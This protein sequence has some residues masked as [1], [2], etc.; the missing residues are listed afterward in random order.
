MSD[1]HVRSVRVVAAVWVRDGRVLAA[2]RGPGQSSAGLWELPGG[3]VEAGETDDAALVREIAEELAC[4]I[5]VVGDS[6]GTSEHTYP[7][8]RVHVVAYP[9]RGVA[10][11]GGSDA[12]PMMT[13]H[14]ALRWLAAH[15]LHEVDWVPADTA[16]LQAVAEWMEGSGAE[17]HRRSPRT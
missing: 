4:P 13:E 8:V 16:L 14:S 3:K 12:E 1:A 5:E 7:H 6:L 2:Q 17:S 11:E 15:E 10:C 9:V